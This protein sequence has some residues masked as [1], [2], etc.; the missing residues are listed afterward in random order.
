MSLPLYITINSSHMATDVVYFVAALTFIFMS[1]PLSITR[2]SSHMA[3]DVVY[4]VAALT[5]IFMQGQLFHFYSF[6]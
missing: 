4:L 1:L 6:A 5:F 2:N 3:T